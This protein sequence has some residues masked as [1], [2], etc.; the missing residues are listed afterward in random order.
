MEI[1]SRSTL[2]NGTIGGIVGAILG[3]VPLVMLVAPLF[4]GGVAGVLERDGPRRGALAGAVAG[5]LMAILG[6]LIRTVIISVRFGDIPGSLPAGGLVPFILASG[7]TI[8]GWVGAIVVASIGGGLGSLLTGTHGQASPGGEIANEAT[9]AR[10]RT[11]SAAVILGSLVAGAVTFGLV[12]L[13]VTATL[14][15]FI[16]PSAL[17][18]LPLGFVAGSVVAVLGYAYLTRG[19]GNERNWRRIGTGALAIAVVFSVVVAGLFVLG[20]DRIDETTES[21]YDYDVSLSANQ[22][23]QN[24]T[25]MVPVPV[26][27]D[28]SALGELFVSEVRY[29][30]HSPAVQGYEPASEPVAFSYELVETEQGLMLAIS[31]ERIEVTSVYYRI[32]ENETMGWHERIDPDEYDPDD[33]TMGVQDDGSFTFSVSLATDRTID[34]ADPFGSEPLLTTTDEL[35][36]IDC[37][38]PASET[39]RCYEYDSYGYASYE[40]ADETVVYVRTGLEGRN[41]WF[42]G[43]WS[44][45]NYREYASIELAGPQAGWFVTTGTLDVGSGN[46]R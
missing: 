19:S 43:G 46:Y 35:R 25:F 30:R 1:L 42:S 15:P 34:T 11:R 9:P 20:G 18:G 14:N 38:G 22:T 29:D 40:A 28:T 41:E 7:L 23:I 17:V 13:A 3:Y 21:T 24:A 10:S 27:N 26:S 2:R 33:P 44:G 37:W 16:W 39:E 32:V 4:G 36:E 12:A 31:T 5:L 45:N 6:T 8:L